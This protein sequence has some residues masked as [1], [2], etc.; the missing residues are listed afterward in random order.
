MFTF[1]VVLRV[2]CASVVK[3]PLSVAVLHRATPL[4]PR[5]RCRHNVTHQNGPFSSL[6]AA[7]HSVAALNRDDTTFSMSSNVIIFMVNRSPFTRWQPTKRRS[8]VA[9]CRTPYDHLPPGSCSPHT[10]EKFKCRGM[11]GFT[12][13]RLSPSAVSGRWSSVVG[14][15]SLVVRRPLPPPA[16]DISRNSY[17]AS[18]PPRGRGGTSEGSSAHTTP[19]AP[20]PNNECATSYPCRPCSRSSAPSPGNQKSSPSSPS[21]CAPESRTRIAHRKCRRGA[22]PPPCPA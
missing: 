6:L 7:S 11:R 10:P 22:T 16:S 15:Q 1:V 12:R 2:L 13:Q 9:R 20:G 19:A 8:T 5:A 18:P 21:E 3:K 17:T 4:P 14:R